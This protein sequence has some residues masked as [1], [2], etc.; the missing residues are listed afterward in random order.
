VE[1]QMKEFVAYLRKLKRNIED[2]EKLLDTG[3]IEKAKELLKQLKEDTQKD[4]EA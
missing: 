4:I 3:N 2:I 1:D